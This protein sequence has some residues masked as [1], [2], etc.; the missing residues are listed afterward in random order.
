MDQNLDQEKLRT[1]SQIRNKGT[2]NWLN[3]LPLEDEGYV[4]NKQ[5]F[6]D[7]LAL[8]YNRSISGS[9][10]TCPCGLPFNTV[11]ALD[12]KKGGFVHSRHDEIQDLEAALLSQVCKDVATEPA[13]QPVTGENFA[14]RSANIEDNARLD[15]KARGF[16]RSGQCAFFDI[17]I[18]HVNSSSYGDLSTEQILDRAEKEKKWAYNSRVM[19][20][21]HGTFTPLVFGTNGA[22]GEEC[23]KFHKLLA[24]KLA[25]KTGK[26]YFTVM[27]WLRTRL[28]FSILRSALLCLR[29]TRVPF[30]RPVSIDTD[31]I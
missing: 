9:P 28:S 8:R 31:F 23:A 1:I 13:L 30:Y 18:A 24:A 6:R 5:E 19:E 16:F 15:V 10:S 3:I 2:S 20:V 25:Q 12:C 22:M 26:H 27:Q 17:R 11:H 4:L 14:L 21:E 7:A 29:G